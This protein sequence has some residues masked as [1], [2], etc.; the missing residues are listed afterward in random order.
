MSHELRT[1]LN[2]ILGFAQLMGRDAGLTTEQQGNLRIINRSGEHLL[3]LINDVLEMSKI[4]AGRVTPQEKS[5]DLYRLLD[6]LEDMFRLR[7]AD[8]GLALTFTRSPAV[9]QFV[10][11]DEGK[12]RQVLMNLLGNG[13]KFTQQGSV[14]LRVRAHSPGLPGKRGR[15]L[16]EV[17]D[18]GPGIAPEE[19]EA[20]F[21]PFV[22]TA[23]GRQSHEGTGLGLSISRRFARLMGGDIT[24]SS[25]LGQGSIFTFEVPVGLADPAEVQVAQP[26]RRMLGLE[27]GQPI[28]RLLIVDEREEARQLLVKLLAPLGFDVREATT[29]R[30]AIEV[31]ESWKPHLIWMDMRMPVMDGYEATR[32][33][34]AA[35]KGRATV[36]VA[37]TASA[38]EEDRQTI[39]SAGCDDVVCK[40]FREDEIF[41]MLAKHLG[42]RFVYEHKQPQPTTAAEVLT[43]AAL[44]GLPDEWLADLHQATIRADWNLILALI[45]EIRERDEALADALADLVRNFEYKRIVALIQQARG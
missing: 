31:W 34:K 27:P 42:T 20:V 36:I 7:A 10:R 44:S 41:D 22:Q 11:M 26:S 25:E 14:T 43:P 13:V 8:K 37:L 33:I 39:L 40:P 16:L 5:F 1:P 24:V 38:F 19:L 32:R 9:P 18:T 35:P 29:G 45:G 23:S 17:E 4:E 12:L 6:T 2:A 15:L 3:A 28:Y 30:E 21:E